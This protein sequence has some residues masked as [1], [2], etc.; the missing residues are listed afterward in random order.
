MPAD[1]PEK[2]IGENEDYFIWLFLIFLFK[3]KLNGR[4]IFTR[5]HPRRAAASL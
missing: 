3:I 2:E 5:I 4:G 1:Y